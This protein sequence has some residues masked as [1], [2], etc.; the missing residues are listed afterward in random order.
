MS[1]RKSISILNIV[2][3]PN[4]NFENNIRMVLLVCSSRHRRNRNTTE[5]QVEYFIKK[6]DRKLLPLNPA[7]NE[8]VLVT[9]RLVI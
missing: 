7:F 9:F 3:L 5:I 8:H 6:I 2:S 4:S 1:F